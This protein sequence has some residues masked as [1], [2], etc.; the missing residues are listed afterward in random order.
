[1]METEGKIDREKMRSFTGRSRTQLI[2]YAR[3]AFGVKSIP[4]P[5][6][7]CVLCE[8]SYAPRLRDMLKHKDVPTIWDA[9]AIAQGR[10]LRLDE[11]AF[12]VV[13]RRLADA[14]ALDELFADPRR[15]R[16]VL[17]YPN[18][19]MGASVLLVTDEAPEFNDEN[20]TVSEKLDSYIQTAGALGLRFSKREKYAAA[21]G[22][23]TCKLKIGATVKIVPV[24][25]NPEVEKIAII[26]E[27]LGPEKKKAEESRET[28]E[29]T[30][31]ETTERD[32]EQVSNATRLT[33]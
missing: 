10:I 19:Y 28:P 26:M 5:S 14:N 24:F 32:A 31:E 33:D 29:N 1:E 17:L 2:S 7:G 11:S 22:G 6:T 3:M 8:N 27:P 12:C 9:K 20:P 25:E 18:N 15:S 16:C 21:E 30:T 13:G 4:Q 23:P